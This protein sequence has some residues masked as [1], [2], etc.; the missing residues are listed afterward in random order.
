MAKLSSDPNVKPCKYFDMIAGTSTG[1]LIA[2]ML[3]RLQMTI[4]ECIEVY[5]TL[6]SQIFSANGPEKI[7]NFTHTGAYYTKDNFE[8]GLK[9]LIRK[10]TGDENAPMLDPDTNN[11]CKVFVVSGQSQDLNHTSAE[12]FRTYATK[13]PDAFAGCAIWEAARATSAAPT[14][15][16]AIQINGVE[17]VDGGLKFNNPSILLMG[18][19]NAVFGIARHIDCLLTIGT[20]MQPNN[21]I[22][23]Q[24]TD[25]LEV[26]DYAASVV[27]AAINVATDCENTHQLAQTLFTGR[28]GVYF[29]FNAGVRQGNDWAPMIALD[30]WRGMPK[31]VAITQTYIGTQTKRVDA[32]AVAL[33]S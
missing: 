6:A 7:W 26:P 9:D 18:E 29:R 4:P 31:L 23:H 17:F 27:K 33:A 11:Q 21:A 25:P 1:G 15:L 10:K 19:V 32:C 28:D 5:T 14:Y 3:G 30:D 24:P 12:Q 22:D 2:I 13:F 20:G 16:P 8:K